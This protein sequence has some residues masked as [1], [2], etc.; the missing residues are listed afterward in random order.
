MSYITE[1]IDL[2]DGN[3]WVAVCAFIMFPTVD[4]EKKIP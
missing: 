2:K 1:Y 3:F 4:D